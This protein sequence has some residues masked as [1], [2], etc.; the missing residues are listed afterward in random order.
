MSQD[1]SHSELTPSL[2]PEYAEIVSQYEKKI[3]DLKTLLEISRSLC[4]TIEFSQLIESILYTCMGQFRVLGAGVFVPEPLDSDYFVLNR[5]YNGLELDPN[6]TYR[7]SV[8]NPLIN[9]I[10]KTDRV[11][12]IDELKAEVPAYA[13]L[14]PIT[15]LKPS[16]IVPLVQR[17][18][19]DGILVL[20]EKISLPEEQ[21][22]SS[23]EKELILTIASLAAVAIYNSTLLERS[24][25]DMMT[26]LKLKYFFYNVLTDKLDAAM[27]QNLPLAVIMFD[28]DFFKRFNDTYGHACG[29][30]VLQTVAKIIRS[31][32]RSC[33]LA[34]R[35]GG[36][37]FTV[38]LDKTGKDDAMTVAERIRRHVE[39]YDFCYENQHVKVTI[40]IGVTVFD[41]EK[42]LVSSPKQLVDQADQAL[43]VSKRSGRNR[44][45]FADERLISEIKITE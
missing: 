44:V 19:L 1:L 26:H 16:L 27:A 25:T 22:Y 21:G 41:S 5:N 29:D 18:H 28:I 8:S 11:F 6:V 34:S 30:Y 45:T 35:Y 2:N 38:M 17:N 20:G 23:Y 15:S 12:T 31:C 24:S 40:S 32:I 7:I 42:N 39:E 37:E 43:Y 4:S 10:T 36:E 14:E 3:Y 13:D 9:V 33:D